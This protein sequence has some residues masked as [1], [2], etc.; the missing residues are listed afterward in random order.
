MN[1]TRRAEMGWK[2]GRAGDE[3][4]SRVMIGLTEAVQ[5][6]PEVYCVFLM[7]DAAPK[8]RL[9]CKCTR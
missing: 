5:A 6:G 2:R 3:G 9:T 7:M 8:K 1:K 4:S